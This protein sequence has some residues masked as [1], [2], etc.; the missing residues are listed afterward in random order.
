MKQIIIIDSRSDRGRGFLN[1]MQEDGAI[2]EGIA[3]LIAKL[4]SEYSPE[5]DMFDEAPGEYAWPERDL[6]PMSSIPE[7]MLNH[8]YATAQAGVP[9]KVTCEL[10]RKLLDVMQG[11]DQD[12]GEDPNF[13]SAIMQGSLKKYHKVLPDGTQIDVTITSPKAVPVEDEVD[14]LPEPSYEKESYLDL[15]KA[16]E[17]FSKLGHFEEGMDRVAEVLAS[18][19]IKNIKVAYADGVKEFLDGVLDIREGNKKLT[20][21]KKAILSKIAADGDTDSKEIVGGFTID[22]RRL[23]KAPYDSEDSAK[24][25]LSSRAFDLLWD[26]YKGG[27]SIYKIKQFYDISRGDPMLERVM[28]DVLRSVRYRD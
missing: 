22:K 7:A 11:A 12:E 14:E 3:P 1:R 13:R 4:I 23:N 17:V 8:L 28:D 25:A 2:P 9:D 18:A 21:D 26:K 16:V 19:A 20:L 10:K 24:K 6:F 27:L 15:D 5:K